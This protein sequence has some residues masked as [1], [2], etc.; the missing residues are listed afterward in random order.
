MKFGQY[1][2]VTFIFHEL[3]F[4]SI[5]EIFLTSPI[6]TGLDS[7]PP[8]NERLAKRVVL[9]SIDGMRHRTFV[10]KKDDE[11]FRAK[12]ILDRACKKGVYARSITQVY[13]RVFI[14]SLSN[15][16]LVANRV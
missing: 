12:H 1:V 11:E 9:V 15:V 4:Y 8:K 10:L 13:S 6:I 2:I 5:F 3:F 7:L 14:F 16:L